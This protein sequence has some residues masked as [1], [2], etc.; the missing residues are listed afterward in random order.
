MP[1]SL[2]LFG[3]NALNATSYSFDVD[4][5]NLRDCT[6]NDTN[7]PNDITGFLMDG[8]FSGTKV[9]KI[10][11]L[12]AIT[13]ISRN[14]DNF[15]NGCFESCYHL[16][17]VT[18]PATLQTIGCRTFSGDFALIYIRCLATTPPTIQSSLWMSGTN[19]TFKI[20]VPDDSVT[21]YKAANYWATYASRIFSLTQFA[22]DFPNG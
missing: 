9:V 1:T 15:A 7:A 6:L 3:S 19:D 13:R 2:Q 17:Y 8:W 16:K 5:P 18:L 10:T 20:Y 4:L 14:A 12:G 21:A 11:N 22:I